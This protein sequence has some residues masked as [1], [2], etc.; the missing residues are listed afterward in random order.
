MI[1][2]SE[3]DRIIVFAPLVACMLSINV[4]CRLVETT[5]HSIYPRL[6]SEVM[7][8]RYKK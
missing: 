8:S 6:T 5:H 4:S 2:C 3:I 1:Y 7:Q